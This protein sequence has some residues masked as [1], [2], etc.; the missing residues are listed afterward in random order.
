MAEKLNDFASRLSKGVPKGL[1]LSVKLLAGASAAVYGVYRSM[2][3]VEGGHRAII[4]NRIG[5]VDLNTIHSE[6]LHFR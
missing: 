2:F 3:T 6:G 1:G 4:F 5:G